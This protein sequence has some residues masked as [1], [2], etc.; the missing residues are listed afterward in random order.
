MTCF[1]VAPNARGTGLMAALLDAAVSQ[2]AEHDA[3]AIEGYPV[4]SAD[5]RVPPG[6]L[7]HGELQTFLDADFRLI[8]RRGR[9]RALVR[10]DL[11]GRSEI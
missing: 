7:Y 3:R 4:D 6:E 5:A 2:A 9:R 10:R 11:T 1:Y 8:D